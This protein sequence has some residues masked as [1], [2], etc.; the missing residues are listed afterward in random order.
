MRNLLD[1]LLNFI[2]EFDTTTGMR[3]HYRPHAIFLPGNF[4]KRHDMADH[5]LPVRLGKSRG[6]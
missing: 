6:Q 3:M 1:Q 4:A 5:P 2:G